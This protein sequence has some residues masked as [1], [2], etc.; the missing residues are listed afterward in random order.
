MR[1]YALCDD[2]FARIEHLLPGRPGWVGQ[3]DLGN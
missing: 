3:R 1:P 2:Q